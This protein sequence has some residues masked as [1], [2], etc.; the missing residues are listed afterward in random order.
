MGGDGERYK[1]SCREVQQLM[2]VINRGSGEE[3]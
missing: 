1:K 3:I 2:W